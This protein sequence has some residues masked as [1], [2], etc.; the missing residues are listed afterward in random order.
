MRLVLDGGLE[1]PYAEN[2]LREMDADGKLGLKSAPAERLALARERT[3]GFPRRW[4][5]SS[6]SSRPTATRPWRKSWP[7]RLPENVTVDLVGEA[8]SRLD[9]TQQRVMQAL[10]VYGH[11]VPPAAVDYLLQPHQPGVDSTP[12][13][14]RL[15]NMHFA[16][17]E[18]GRFYLHP[19][20]REYALARLA[21]G[22]IPDRWADEPAF[23]R[24]G[25]RHRAA[26]YFKQARLPQE[27]WKTI[28]DLAPQLAEFDLRCDGQD[29][30]TAGHVLTAISYDYLMLWGWN[31]RVVE[32]NEGL[33]GK[34][35][36]SRLKSRILCN[37]GQAYLDLGQAKRAIGYHERA[38]AIDREA[39]DHFNEGTDLGNLGLCYSALGQTSRAI[40]YHEQA[41]AIK[42]EVGDRRE[43][44]STLGNLGLCYS[45]LGQTSRAIDY[46]KQS[47]AIAREVG[48]RGGEGITLGNLGTCHSALGQTSRAIDYH[49]QALAIDRE[50]GDRRVEGIDLGDLGHC[51]SALGQTSRAIDYHEQALAI[52]REV[53]NRG[54]EGFSH[55]C[56]SRLSIDEGRNADAI[57]QAIEAVR[58]GDET[59]YLRLIS[60]ANETLALARLCVG[61]L[62]GARSRGG[63]RLRAR[64]PG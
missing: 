19:V 63:S 50:V 57:P 33:L 51:H 2:I 45:A 44:G 22:E 7:A 46:H 39:G 27:N 12:V 8:F 15:V 3:R 32:L 61:D 40:D 56:L 26:E 36:D 42:R 48:D 11:P 47:L 23:T 18:A 31:R 24:Y 49:E 59:G 41:L 62:P 43:E 55:L 37:Q 29:Y 34:L 25:L 1:S 6:R 53:G 21:P 60:F 5:P 52:A 13:L 16:R 28:E 30:E 4:R 54:S 10:A 35:D 58:I 17:K 9:P 38:L 20:D 64:C 14:G